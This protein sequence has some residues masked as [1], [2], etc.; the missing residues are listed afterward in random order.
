MATR[1]LTLLASLFL[2][3]ILL[4]FSLL[5]ISASIA[6]PATLSPLSDSTDNTSVPF[7]SVTDHPGGIWP[8]QMDHT[9]PPVAPAASST[10]TETYI[11]TQSYNAAHGESI[12]LQNSGLSVTI[13]NNLRFGVYTY[14]IGMGHGRMFGL[15]SYHFPPP[16]PNA[17]PQDF[18]TIKARSFI[19]F[20]IHLPVRALTVN[21]AILRLYVYNWWDQV[22]ANGQNF[23]VYALT[24]P[25]SEAE[26]QTNRDWD[27]LPT[28]DQQLRA[29]THITALAGWYEWDV[30]EI[31]QAWHI[32]ELTR[33]QGLT[34]YGFMMAAPPATVG[35]A[36]AA[37]KRDVVTQ[38]LTPRLEIEYVT[39][40]PP[41]ASFISSTPD[42]WG[43]ITVFTNTSDTSGDFKEHVTYNWDFGDGQTSAEKHPQ[44]SYAHTGTYTITLTVDNVVG[45][46]IFSDIVNIHEVILRYLEVFPKGY[47][48]VETPVDFTAVMTPGTEVNYTWNFGDGTPLTITSQPFINHTYTQI[49]SYEIILVA[50][51]SASSITTTAIVTVC[52]SPIFNLNLLTSSPTQLGFP[53]YFTSTLLS[54][55]NVVYL[56]DVGDGSP[57]P[58]S[59]QLATVMHTYTNESNTG[60]RIYLTATNSQ[61]QV[62]TSTLVYVWPDEPIRDLR[63]HSDAPTALGTLTHFTPTMVTGSH[64]RYQWDYGDGSTGASPMH[65]YVATGTYTMILTV[66]NRWGYMTAT[67]A[68]TIYKSHEPIKNLSIFLDRNPTPL[69]ES[70]LFLADTTAGDHITYHWWFGDDAEVITTSPRIMYT[71][72]RLGEYL[73]HLTAFNDTSSAEAHTLVWSWPARLAEVSISHSHC[74]TAYS[75]LLFTPVLTPASGTN[76]DLLW[77]FGDGKTTAQVNPTHI[78]K[79]LGTYSVSVIARNVWG[80]KNASS[81]VC[82]YEAPIQ[83]LRLSTS[84]PASLTHPI[85]FTAT[86]AT[87]TNIIYEWNFG[88]TEGMRDTISTTHHTYTTTGTYTVSLTARNSLTPETVLTT[89]LVQ[90]ESIQGLMLTYHHSALMSRTVILTADIKT[91]TGITY[92]WDFGDGTPVMTSP[93]H[94]VEHVY[95][96]VGTYTVILV[97]QNS[98][99]TMTTSINLHIEDQPIQGLTIDSNSPIIIGQTA[100]FTAT[101]TGVTNVQ[102]WWDFGDS[103]VAT[104]QQATQT[105]HYTEIGTYTVTVVA[106][107]SA[108][109][110]TA[111]TFISIQNES[112]RN[113]EL[114]SNNPITVGQMAVFTVTTIGG[115]NVQ[116]WWD[117]GDGTTMAAQQTTQTHYYVK[118]RVYTITVV[119]SNSTN[120]LTATTIISIQNRSIHTWYLPLILVQ[121]SKTTT[122]TDKIP[123]YPTR[124]P[125]K[126][127]EVF[128]TQTLT[129][130]PGLITSPTSSSV[131]YFSA[132]P[133]HPKPI[134]V[135]DQM[136]LVVNKQDIFTHTFSTADTSPTYAMVTITHSII[137]QIITGNVVLEYRDVYGGLVSASEMWLIQVTKP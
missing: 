115:T 1:F 56:W 15:S 29:T 76:V 98:V 114:K 32:H 122:L 69:G 64:I 65:T 112:I 120:A 41:Q 136:A 101:V 52:D 70:T 58:T 111:T 50:T 57:P 83:D 62:V 96:T 97:A 127:G 30:T 89:V 4:S 22:P 134:M 80:S 53:T 27:T 108:K 107:N 55:T 42:E 131:F 121:W 85:Y 33:S 2:A 74:I 38:T 66:T 110:V 31:V 71:Y 28:F 126:L 103:T 67:H 21:H 133:F 40:E 61:S 81:E 51:N 11:L 7:P 72:S 90:D 63:I 125:I 59:T 8:T 100:T 132:S 77:D 78:Y 19:S 14:P 113:L 3:A 9:P 25:W 68:V 26:F 24:Q 130:N 123:L 95:P 73:V 135:D 87:G 10:L 124:E 88:N 84:S 49:G 12:S 18:A 17:S 37:H 116:Y 109:T 106:I 44:H 54:G 105:H 91:G 119:A 75:P 48:P 79:T 47:I 36:M 93:H 137:T 35:W 45:R 92:F 6:S 23:A 82:V 16:D 34:N 39:P 117:F 129:I 99:N 118:A 43:Q 13:T 128:F 94:V 20:P 60:Y 104:T 5:A 86:M 46:D 102:Y